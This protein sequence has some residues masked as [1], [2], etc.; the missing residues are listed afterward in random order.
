MSK[1]QAAL[2]DAG[3]AGLGQQ[4]L[5]H[6]RLGLVAGERDLDELAASAA[7][8]AAALVAAAGAAAAVGAALVRARRGL[9]DVELHIGDLQVGQVVGLD[10][11][12]LFV[13]SETIT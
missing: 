10:V 1:P 2:Q 8:T 5:Q 6:F 4:A 11:R 3:D 12:R 13:C 7:A 9:C